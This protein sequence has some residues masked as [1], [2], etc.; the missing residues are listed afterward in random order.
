MSL[1]PPP[2]KTI[3]YRQANASDPFVPNPAVLTSSGWE[4]LY[5]ELHQQP[6]FEIAEHQHTMHVMACGLPNIPED[7]VFAIG[8]RWLA[9]KRE[10]E[11]RQLGD[12]AIIPAGIDHRCNWN[13]T[14][15]FGILAIEPALLQH[16]GQDWINP[17]R[18][19]LTPRFMNDRD[20]LIQGIFA[21]LS[22]ELA[23]GGIG[24]NLLVDS[25]RTA[26]AIHLLR[27]YCTTVPKL[28]S[29]ANGLSAATLKLVTDYINAHLDGNLKLVDLN[30]IAN[31]SPY[32]FL[33]LFK[34]SLGVTPHQYILQQRLDRAKYLL[35]SSNLDIS[36]IAL[37]VGFCDRSHLNRCFKSI[38]G[39]TPSQWRQS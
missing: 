4:N 39:K 29:Y 3:D 33:R 14:A 16:I 21:T 8:E 36:E 20:D 18:I 10:T 26:L 32:H 13:T 7:N 30:A 5:V 38:T 28:S 24:G 11:R 9:G 12:I 19:E 6:K 35:R 27:N 1:S 31:I 34:Q 15:R 22:S 37:R 2:T 23:T 17:D 25:L